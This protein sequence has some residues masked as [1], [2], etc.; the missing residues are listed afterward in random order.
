MDDTKSKYRHHTV[1]MPKIL[2][3]KIEEVVASD[4]HGFTS[5]PDFIK[6]ATRRYLRE[7]GYLE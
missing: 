4:K 6:E 1:N 2:A 3:D 7:L 5:V